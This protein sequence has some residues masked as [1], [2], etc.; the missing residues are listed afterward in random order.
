M[1]V[2]THA[3]GRWGGR[4][5][6]GHVCVC[7]RE[8]G[9]DGVSREGLTR[10][11]HVHALICELVGRPRLF[12]SPRWLTEQLSDLKVNTPDRHPGALSVRC[13]SGFLNRP[14]CAERRISPLG[15]GL[16]RRPGFGV[17]LWSSPGNV[18]SSGKRR[19]ATRVPR[20]RPEG[21]GELRR[22]ESCR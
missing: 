1:H 2:H 19:S 8:G 17:W 22:A 10:K 11:G 3:C 7:W 4:D 20:I 14:R 16:L 13:P 15:V 9:G 5:G 18:A 12:C 21:R 6:S